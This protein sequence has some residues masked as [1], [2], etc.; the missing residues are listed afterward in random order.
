M[1]VAW[2]IA[3][4]GAFTL[5]AQPS[6]MIT[7]FLE[8]HCYECHDDDVQKGDRRLDTLVSPATAGK[9]R[10]VWQTVFDLIDAGDMPPHKKARARPDPEA[11]TS[12]L[13]AI[14]QDMR[15]GTQ[16]I[17]L[18]RMNRRE[19]ENTV[20]DLLGIRTPLAEI[21]PEDSSVQGFDNV[22]NGLS[23]SSELMSAYLE[24]ANAAFDGVIRR[25]EP[26]KPETRRQR[27][28]DHKNA[29]S[30]IKKK[31]GG[32]IAIEG[33]FVDFSPGWPPVEVGGAHPIEDGV[34]RARIAVWPH[35][36]GDRTLAVA[37]YVGTQHGTGKRRFVG[38]YDVRGTPEAPHIIE[39]TTWMHEGDAIHIKVQVSPEHVTWRHKDEPRPGIGVVW[40]ETY[41]PLDQSF[42]S[43][44]QNALFGP[45][46][47]ME[48]GASKYMRHRK[49]VRLNHVV[50]ASPKEDAER[51]IRDFVPRAFRRPV[52]KPLVDQFV[53]L[54]L[55]RMD[56][57]RSFEQ[58]VRTGFCAVLCSPHFLLLNDEP[59]V[60][61][62]SIASRM[63][64]FLWSSMPDDE[65]LQLAA[66]GKLKDRD[67]RSSQVERI[68]TDPKSERFVQNFT[69]QW[70]DLRDIEFTTPSKKLFPEF[71]PLLQEAM[72]AETRG[73]FRHVLDNDLS[74][75]EFIDSDFT[76]LNER[77]ARHYGIPGIKGHEEMRV[78]KLPADSVRGGLLTHAS[79]L[80]VT[81]NGTNSSPILR[82]VWVLDA[83]LG[84]PVLPPPAGV[85]AVEP[86]IRGAT[87]IREQLD[88]HKESQSCAR[89]HAR[90]DPPGFALECFDPIGGYRDRYRGLAG[91]K[92]FERV[93]KTKG[94][95]FFCLPVEAGGAMR[96]GR[97]FADF[98]DFRELLKGDD[99]RVARSLASKLLIYGTGRPLTAAN[100]DDVAA[101]VAAARER[102]LG[103]RSMIHAV[104]QSDLFL[105]P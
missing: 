47:T 13:K 61:A 102:D 17:A 84:A 43:E 101:V 45:G 104:V 60:D 100:R 103:L 51:I 29:K 97:Q 35:N 20:H 81:A 93:A 92:N 14:S 24:A 105:H 66:S 76:V 75:M 74:V 89:C 70:L 33:A 4:L 39:F 80:K 68:L 21:L 1:R 6:P 86:D 53:T 44:A 38:I 46:M 59:T 32:V 12:V 28:L 63:S 65:L 25:I 72:L 52:V 90:I 18:R 40:A 95:Y 78:V 79:I 98:A 34:F 23:I 27:I 49:G 36:P 30:S 2:I 56:A 19:Y 5:V 67:L 82:G 8:Q 91:G 9:H 48:P 11:V 77:L 7:S 37:I 55:E 16:P 85:P 87:T 42:P 73:F 94:D 88:K 71:D 58:A 64:Y 99:E 26:L 83:I 41:G 15:A 10:T 50:S 69:G 57:G 22:S 54:T 31:A 96:D 3:L 62:Y